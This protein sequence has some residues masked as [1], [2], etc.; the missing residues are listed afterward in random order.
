MF[1]TQATIFLIII[2]YGIKSIYDQQVVV[3]KTVAPVPD[4][5]TKKIIQQLLIN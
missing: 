5:K 4:L 2:Y 1:R 3:Y